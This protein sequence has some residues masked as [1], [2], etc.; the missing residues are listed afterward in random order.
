MAAASRVAQANAAVEEYEE[1]SDEVDEEEDDVD[2][3]DEVDT[4]G[5]LRQPISYN[6]TLLELHRRI[7]LRV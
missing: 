6:R 1:Y 5:R 4:S 3:G 2:P 7:S